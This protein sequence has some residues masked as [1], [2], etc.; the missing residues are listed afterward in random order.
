MCPVKKW[1]RA[2]FLT[3]IHTTHSFHRVVA[4]PNINTAAM[5]W[6]LAF[7]ALIYVPSSAL[8]KVIGTWE[9]Q[10]YLFIDVILV[11]IKPCVV[12]TTFTC[13]YGQE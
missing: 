1:I 12:N 2:F 9:N 3:T 8:V 6:F 13:N 11:S 10:I 5:V 4:F 7:Q